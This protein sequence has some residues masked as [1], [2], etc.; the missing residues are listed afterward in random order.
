MKALDE[1]IRKARTLRSEAVTLQAPT[2]RAIRAMLARSEVSHPSVPGPY[3]DALIA[4]LRRDDLCDETEG[5]HH[6][7]EYVAS[8]LMAFDT[9]LRA[10]A[11]LTREV[12]E[13]SETRTQVVYRQDEI[14]G[15]AYRTTVTE[16]AEPSGVSRCTSEGEAGRCMLTSGHCGSHTV[17]GGPY[18]DEPTSLDGPLAA[19]PSGVSLDVLGRAIEAHVEAVHAAVPKQEWLSDHTCHFGCAY[20]IRARLAQTQEGSDD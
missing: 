1:A 14:G 12:A 7:D 16:V 4:T 9:E 2:A 17:T 20:D 13:P 5:E 19:E 6:T 18:T 15:R 8:F 11:A 10:R 3:V